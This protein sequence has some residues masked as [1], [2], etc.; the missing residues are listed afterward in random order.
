MKICRVDKRGIAAQDR[1]NA[2]RNRN[3]GFER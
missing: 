1:G 3:R 2:K